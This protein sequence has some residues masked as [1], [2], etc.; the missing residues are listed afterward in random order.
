MLEV[1][2]HPVVDTSNF[3]ILAHSE[4][5]FGW[6]DH[7]FCHVVDSIDSGVFWNC[8]GSCEAFASGWGFG[9]YFKTFGFGDR[10]YAD[11]VFF[12]IIEK[13]NF[14]SAIWCVGCGLF[15]SF[16][17]FWGFSVPVKANGF[18]VKRSDRI[19]PEICSANVFV[20]FFI[21]IFTRFV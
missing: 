12:Y 20:C 10:F 1:Y 5:Y 9:R 18:M 11:L 7:F 21:N 17:S 4:L 8:G 15:P 14:V 13:L 6:L 16:I 3:F 2:S 19:A